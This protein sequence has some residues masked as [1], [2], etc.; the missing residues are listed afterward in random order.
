MD[1]VRTI[2]YF[3]EKRSDKVI[4]NL[5]DLF[6]DEMLL[7]AETILYRSY[8]KRKYYT[9]PNLLN[10]IKIGLDWTYTKVLTV[11]SSQPFNLWLRFLRHLWPA[12][13]IEIFFSSW[14]TYLNL[15]EFSLLNSNLLRSL[16]W[17]SNFFKPALDLSKGDMDSY[18]LWLILNLLN[19]FNLYG[20]F[21]DFEESRPANAEIKDHIL[22]DICI[23]RK[24]ITLLK[25][26]LL[27]R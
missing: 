19:K 8:L 17:N 23:L 15:W 10:R 4:D 5:Q 12:L 3:I 9:L 20:M 24:S 27:N 2:S 7:Y 22:M 13:R 16:R 25:H 18:L 21:S 14:W 6:S 1:L 26:S 11:I